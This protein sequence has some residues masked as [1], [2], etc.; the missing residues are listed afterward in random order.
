ML[1]RQHTISGTIDF[2]IIVNNLNYGFTFKMFFY[3]KY[4]M[5]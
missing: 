2:N 5:K 4:V 3:N 1:W